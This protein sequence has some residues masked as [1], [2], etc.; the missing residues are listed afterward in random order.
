VKRTVTTITDD[1]DGT[2]IPS[3]QAAPP[4]MLALNDR[5]VV[6][7]LTPARRAELADMLAPFL[8]AGKRVKVPVVKKVTE[9]V[10][11]RRRS[12]R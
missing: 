12:R 6:L 7:D 1:L 4:T 8:A 11:A 3:E 2:V 5:A 9:L 10:P